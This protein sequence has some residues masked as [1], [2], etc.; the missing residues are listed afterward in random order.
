MCIPI[1]GTIALIWFVTEHRWCFMVI[2][3][4]STIIVCQASILIEGPTVRYL[5]A[6]GLL[7]FLLLSPPLENLLLKLKGTGIEKRDHE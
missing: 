4:V 6:L 1:Y 3:L 2:L 7:S 5:H